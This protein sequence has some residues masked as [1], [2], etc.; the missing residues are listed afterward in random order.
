MTQLN[1]G[2]TNLIDP[3]VTPIILFLLAIGLLCFWLFFRCTN[4][5]EKI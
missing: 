5:F 1:N 3:M 4:W 2:P